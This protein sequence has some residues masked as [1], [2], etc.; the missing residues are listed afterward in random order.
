[1]SEPPDDDE[2][3]EQESPTSPPSSMFSP[4]IATAAVAKICLAV[5][6]VWPPKL[7]M[8]FRLV[9]VAVTHKP[10]FL[11]SRCG[12]TQRGHVHAKSWL[13]SSDSCR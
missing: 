13:Q 9:G 6:T 5:E 11:S 1:M 12:L 3:R 2:E 4:G 7:P 10:V 8:T